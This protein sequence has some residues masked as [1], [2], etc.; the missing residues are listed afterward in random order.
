VAKCG[1][2]RFLSIIHLSKLKL[3]DLGVVGSQNK[4]FHL[5]VV[6]NKQFALTSVT[7]GYLLV[8]LLRWFVTRGHTWSHMP[9]QAGLDHF[10]DVYHLHDA[11]ALARG[12][13]YPKVLLSMVYISLA[14][15][16]TYPNMDDCTLCNSLKSVGALPFLDLNRLCHFWRERVL[17]R[18]VKLSKLSDG[19]HG[20]LVLLHVCSD[21]SKGEIA[22]PHS[23]LPFPSPNSHARRCLCA[24]QKRREGGGGGGGGHSAFHMLLT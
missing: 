23:P 18:C 22:S 11:K 12:H 1:L 19:C 6:P 2:I 7:S 24:Y 16:H 17:L 9:F 4:R 15:G 10:P 20:F 21:W 13:L 5:A 3:C 8:E 14:L